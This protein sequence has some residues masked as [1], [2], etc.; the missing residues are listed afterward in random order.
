LRLALLNH[1]VKPV[2]LQTLQG[3]IA[4]HFGDA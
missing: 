4:G 3:L 1:L 2:D